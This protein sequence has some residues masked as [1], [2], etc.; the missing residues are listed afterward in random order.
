MDSTDEPA[1]VATFR[2]TRAFGWAFGALTDRASFARSR[3]G[4]DTSKASAFRTFGLAVAAFPLDTVVGPAWIAPAVTAATAATQKSETI[5]T[6]AFRRRRIV[7]PR[8]VGSP[9]RR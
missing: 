3:S 6:P 8:M 5:G 1:A 7:A 9:F 4:L 2:S